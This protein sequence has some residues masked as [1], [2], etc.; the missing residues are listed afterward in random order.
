[1][2]QRKI[3]FTSLGTWYWSISKTYTWSFSFNKL[4]K[5]F[6]NGSFKEGHVCKPRWA[7]MTLSND[8]LSRLEPSTPHN[9]VCRPRVSARLWRDPSSSRCETEAAAQ[10]FRVQTD[11]LAEEGKPANNLRTRC[12]FSVTA[13][14]IAI[15]T[16]VKPAVPF[17]VFGGVRS[18]SSRGKVSLL[19]ALR[20]DLFLA[21]S[22]LLIRHYLSIA[23]SPKINGTK[24]N[25]TTI[26]NMDHA[27]KM[28]RDTPK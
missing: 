22:D 9:Q 26:K 3:I 2:K 20:K 28:E 1:M 19:R 25:K 15:R 27:V 23:A 14:S 13:L 11:G 7:N 4:K 6:Q 18:I 10:T 17:D 24:N 21:I 5:I 12:S 8:C 16:L